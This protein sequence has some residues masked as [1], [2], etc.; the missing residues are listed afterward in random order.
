MTLSDVANIGTLAS[1]VAVLV[2]LVYLSM[3]VRQT[4]RN[5]QALLSQ[6]VA[7]RGVETLRWSAEPGMAALRTRVVSGETRFTDTEVMQLMF[8]MRSMIV[9]NQDS[10][11]QHATGLIDERTLQM[12]V[13]GLRAHL[14]APVFRAIWAMIRE[15]FPAETGAYIDQVI[16]D[17]PLSEPT[18]L[19]A[20]LT[21]ELAA[22]EGSGQAAPARKRRPRLPR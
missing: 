10:R 9:V 15:E 11:L 12:T 18:S 21:R 7:N 13:G 1:A 8:M 6:S 17:T 5:Q 19:A 4:E 22:L 14:R 3:Q 2:S 16:R 20:R